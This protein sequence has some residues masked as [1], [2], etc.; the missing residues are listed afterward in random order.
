MSSPYLSSEMIPFGYGKGLE[1][2]EVLYK[3]AI[4]TDEREEFLLLLSEVGDCTLTTEMNLPLQPRS[5]LERH[6]DYV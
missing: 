3:A 1:T 2:W 4:T 6:W 5:Q